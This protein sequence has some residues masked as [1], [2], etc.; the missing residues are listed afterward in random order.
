VFFPRRALAIALSC[1]I[2]GCSE[3][4]VPTPV[5]A[6]AGEWSRSQAS[7]PGIANGKVI[8]PTAKKTWKVTTP[9][10]VVLDM[11]IETGELEIEANGKLERAKSPL[12]AT[13]TVK[14]NDVW[15]I[16]TQDLAGGPWPLLNDAFEVKV[17]RP[18]IVMKRWRRALL[19]DIDVTEVSN[20]K[21]FG[22]G[23]VEAEADG[24]GRKAK[25]E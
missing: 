1:A 9:Q 12:R 18:T 11:A 5:G 14:Q 3:R 13:F 2:A 17:A 21:I 4:N 19:R 6:V 15:T 24:T 8:E 10:G 25:I 22:D 16:S 23:R 20:L 7:A